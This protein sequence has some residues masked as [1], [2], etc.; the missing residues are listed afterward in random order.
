ME[1]K[2]ELIAGAV[3]V[4]SFVL[5][6]LILLCWRMRMKGASDRQLCCCCC[7]CGPCQKQ[8]SAETRN[9]PTLNDLLFEVDTNSETGWLNVTTTVQQHHRQGDGDDE[10]ADT[11]MREAV[12][13]E[14]FFPALLKGSKR[15][16]RKEQ[17]RDPW[18]E[19]LL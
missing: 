15:I 1:H 3:V 12:S 10:D 2:D 16:K 6:L 7:R 11:T 9:Y 8:N 4:S 5:A 14:T 19:P 17:G 13:V 18:Q